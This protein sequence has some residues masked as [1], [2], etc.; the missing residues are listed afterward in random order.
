METGAVKC[1]SSCCTNNAQPLHVYAKKSHLFLLGGLRGCILVL[2]EMIHN[3]FALD[4]KEHVLP[5]SSEE[6]FGYLNTETLPSI[7]CEIW[8]GVFQSH[9]RNREVERF[10]GDQ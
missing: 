6:V 1:P 3:F 9:L 8:G 2:T 10:I 7:P 5:A 4:R